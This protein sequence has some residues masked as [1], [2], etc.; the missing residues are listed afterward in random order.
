MIGSSEAKQV[1]RNIDF[2]RYV[3]QEVDRS[4]LPRNAG[5]RDY[6]CHFF[7]N[8]GSRNNG[9]RVSLLCI[10]LNLIQGTE[11]AELSQ[12]ESV[13]AKLLLVLGAFFSFFNGVGR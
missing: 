9:F 12:S 13:M 10:T 7:L 11:H 4:R 5:R 1:L 3:L 8:T 2:K 6:C